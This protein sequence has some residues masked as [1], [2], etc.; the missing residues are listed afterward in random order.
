ML[1]NKGQAEARL[2][3]EYYLCSPFSNMGYCPVWF[4]R[5]WLLV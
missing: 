1:K 2:N 5:L 3:K 4:V